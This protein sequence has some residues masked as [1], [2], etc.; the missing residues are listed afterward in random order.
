MHVS[1]TNDEEL[2]EVI[3]SR[4]NVEIIVS[5]RKLQTQFFQGMKEAYLRVYHV[6]ME[7][8]VAEDTSGIHFIA[9]A[10]R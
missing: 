4:T 9:P 5:N 8:D 6:P 10:N 3:C 1:G 7:K 2:I